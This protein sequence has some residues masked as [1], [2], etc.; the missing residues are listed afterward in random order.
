MN[1]KELKAEIEIREKSDA[2]QFNSAFIY[3]EGD[4]NNAALVLKDVDGTPLVDVSIELYQGGLNLKIQSPDMGND[5]VVHRLLEGI[6]EHCKLPS[7]TL[8]VATHTHRHGTTT[9]T[10]W[11]PTPAEPPKGNE[12]WDIYPTQ[13]EVVEGLDIDFEPDRDEYIDITLAD[14]EIPLIPR[15]R[16]N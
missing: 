7:A 8:F 4:C 10:F 2:H 1:N 15:K 6:P 5:V 13:D 9:Y 3:V 11:Y 12:P 16:T 14:S